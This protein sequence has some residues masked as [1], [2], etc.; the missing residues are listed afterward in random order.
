MAN[1]KLFLEKISLLEGGYVN[2]PNDKGGCTNK[3]ITLSTFQQYYGSDK[4]CEDLKNITDKQVENIYLKGFWNPCWGDKIQCPRIANLIVDWA[5]NSGVRTAIKGVQ[6]IVGTTA[7]GIMGNMTLK[8]INTYPCKD[9]FDKIKEARMEFYNNLVKKN[10]SQKVFL[11]GWNNR[12]KA[13]D[14]C[15]C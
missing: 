2:H 9:L 3:G 1:I 6:K 13:Y 12:L 15:E 8:A 5:V 11:N 4:T 14:W 7:D 10:P